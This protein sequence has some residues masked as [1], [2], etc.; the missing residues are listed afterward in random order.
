MHKWGKV[1]LSKNYLESLSTDELL[2]LC[3]IYGLFVPKD[4]NRNFVI[5][6]LLYSDEAE[7]AMSDTTSSSEILAEF[8]QKRE[9]EEDEDFDYETEFKPKKNK[10]MKLSYNLTGIHILLRDPMWLF[11]FWDFSKKE[12]KD[13]TEQIDFDTFVLRIS[14][15]SEDNKNEPY[16]YYDIEVDKNDRSR[17]FYLSFDDVLTRVD[18]CARFIT[19][20]NIK[21][22]SESNF[23]HLNRSNIPSKLCVLDSKIDKIANYSGISILKKSHF[24]NYR[25]AFRDIKEE[26][27]ER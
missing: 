18:L 17:Y 8:I 20:E 15:F 22:I 24:K 2:K 14:L 11:A 13:I 3:D 21:I 25:Q 7:D 4:L 26:K 9:E 1:K 6:E 27:C 12:F 5:E 10:K 16:E 19:D 23:I